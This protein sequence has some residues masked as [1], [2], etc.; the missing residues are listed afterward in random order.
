MKLFV[1]LMCG[2]LAFAAFAEKVEVETTF[3][4][5]TTKTETFDVAFTGGVAEFRYPKAAISPETKAILV[6]PAFCRA[7]VGEPGY[8]MTGDGHL[9]YFTDRPDVKDVNTSPI[10]GILPMPFWGMKKGDAAFVAIVKGMPYHF[11]AWREVKDGVYHIYPYFFHR[12]DKAY[13]DIVISFTKLS[14]ADADYSGMARTYR[15]YQIDRGEVKPLKER[16][17]TAPELAYAVR[18]PE[19]RVRMAWKPVPSPEP[20]QTDLNE[21]SVYPAI[22]FDRFK[23]IAAEFKRQGIDGAE[24][25]LVGWNIGGHDG[26]WPQIFP[27]EPSLGGE[28]KLREAIKFA[29]DQG[30]QV[31]A[32]GNHRDA[33]MIADSWDLEYIIEKDKDG[34]RIP[35]KTTW[36]GGAMHT[37]CPQRQYERFALKDLHKVRALGFKGL[38]YLDVYSCVPA[39]ACDDPRH[40]L[41][42][43][44]ATKYIGH[45]LD[46]CRE[47]FGGSASEGAWDHNIKNLDSTLY[48]TFSHPFDMKKAMAADR[49][50][51]VGMIDRCIPAYQLVYNGYVLSN[52]FTTTVNAMLKGRD[53]ELKLIEFGGR[54]TFYYHANFK[55]PEEKIVDGKRVITTN[56]W[57]GDEDLLCRNIADVVSSAEK[58]K[59]AIAF[60]DKLWHLQYATMDHH[61]EVAPNVF[62]TRYSTGEEVYVNYNEKPVTVDGVA[63]SAKGW[64]LKGKQK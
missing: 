28:V 50:V 8:W 42:E 43:R 39:P 31:A 61:D 16:V 2:A 34:K 17:K 40:P 21:P 47:V 49:A 60:Y 52:P 20:N 63:V 27:V 57:M 18:W 48:V 14:G 19:V 30:Y 36:G 25:C 9:G 5:G 26:R 41:N 3:K 4:D 7:K 56:N 37:I 54:P 12:M 59:T 64:I 45:V 53:N 44:E 46:L 10:T 51:E 58:I 32:H 33:Y 38:H 24:F 11:C 1:L 22:P 55:S 62:R 15:K 23:Q 13:E 6:K 35:Q 29:Q